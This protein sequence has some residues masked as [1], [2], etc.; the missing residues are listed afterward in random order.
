[1]HVTHVQTPCV[2]QLGLS[3]AM[4]VAL[5]AID[6][7]S[8]SNAVERCSAFL[9]ILELLATFTNVLSGVLEDIVKG[10]VQ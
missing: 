10:V 9:Y 3:G 4:V 2:D 5:Y 7:E 6:E 1:M 8:K